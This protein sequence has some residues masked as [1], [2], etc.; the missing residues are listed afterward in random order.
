MKKNSLL[1]R[2]GLAED[3][4]FLFTNRIPRI[5]LTHAIGWFSQIKSPWLTRMSI[6]VWRWFTPL[7]FSEAMFW[8]YL[9]TFIFATELESL[10]KVQ[11][12]WRNNSVRIIST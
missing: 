4:N 8:S 11:Q 7:D 2:S 12:S 10:L 5:T 6:A 3:L 9:N 1:Q